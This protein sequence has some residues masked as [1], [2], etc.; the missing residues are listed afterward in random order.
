MRRVALLVILILAFAVRAYGVDFPRYH[1]DENTNMDGVLYA[2]YHRLALPTYVHGSFFQYSVLALWSVYLWVSGVA[3]TTQNLLLAF[4][5]DTQVLVLARLFLVAVGTMTVAVTYLLGKRL[6]NTTTGL[7]AAFFLA[8]TCLHT[9]ESHYA[10]GHVL[11]AFLVTL[12]V[13]FCARILHTGRARD[14]VLAGVSIGL[15]T[16]AQYSALLALAPLIVAHA[17]RARTWRARLWHRSLWLGLDSAGI[18]FFLV[19]PY[20]LLNFP[21]F[22]GEMKW[23]LTQVVSHTWVD[24]EGQPVWLFY[25]TEHL[26]NGMGLGLEIVALLGIVYALARHRPA[27][28]VLLAFPLLLFLSLARGENFARYAL[29]LLPFLTIAAA[30]GLHDLAERLRTRVAPRVVSLSLALVAGLLMLPS[31]QNIVRYD[32]WLT[33]PDTRAQAA[34]WI[35]THIPREASIVVE[36]AGVLGPPVPPSRAMLDRLIDPTLRDFGSLYFW[37]MREQISREDGYRVETV[38]RLDERHE[39]GI[40]VGKV[41]SASEY[42]ARGVDY[43]VTVS[44]MQ[45]DA[46]SR[47]APEFAQSLAAAY[48]PVA[49]FR[50]TIV[51]RFDPYAWRMDYEALARVVPGQAGVGGPIL[52]IYQRRLGE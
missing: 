7:L 17:W 39:G 50:P 13:Y 49:E 21:F 6:Y 14:Y 45:R 52:R 24:A 36:G 51:F 20:A 18:A 4:F 43:V 5:R 27:D 28:W 40:L 31:F 38:F 9:F 35:R 19:T 47:Y 3:P 44:W 11:A 30:R 26:R 29:P 15:A 8:L 25:L 33:Q 37:A 42:V 41:A 34:E 12:A 2:S 22:A 46:S 23:F 32:F 16:A 48:V 10:R 1:W